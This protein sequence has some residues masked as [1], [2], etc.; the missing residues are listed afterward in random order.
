M[1]KCLDVSLMAAL[2]IGHLWVPARNRVRA[3]R[4]NLF[5]ALLEELDDFAGVN[6]RLQAVADGVVV[7]ILW[8]QVQALGV[9]VAVGDHPCMCIWD[10]G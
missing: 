7:Q 2:F 9:L 3:A 1:E 5:Q 10:H 4:A 6:L 8:D